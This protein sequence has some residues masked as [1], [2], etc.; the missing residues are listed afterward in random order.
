MG[1]SVNQLV[2]VEHFDAGLAKLHTRIE[3][4]SNRIDSVQ[5][6]LQARI[7]SLR[8]EMRAEIVR[9]HLILVSILIAANALMLTILSSVPR[10]HDI[11]EHDSPVH[12]P[13]RAI[14]EG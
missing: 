12:P 11:R 4:Q 2:T 6:Q 7:D 9:S 13:V 8:V 3:G 10:P 5:T 1:G 14:Q